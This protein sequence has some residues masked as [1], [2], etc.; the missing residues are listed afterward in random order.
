MSVLAAVL[1]AG[2][3]LAAQAAPDRTAFHVVSL[4]LGPRWQKDLPVRQQPGIAEHGRYM[5]QLSQEGVLVLG[6]PF[7]ADAAAGTVSGAMVILA[8]AD[9]AEARRRM[10][11]DPGVTSGLLEIADVRRLVVGT[12]AWRPWAKPQPSPHSQ[13]S[14]SPQPQP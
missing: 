10:E 3:A 9:P 4:N 12:G 11:R 1:F 13:A 7:L 8:T 5:E 2:S 14:P 6:G